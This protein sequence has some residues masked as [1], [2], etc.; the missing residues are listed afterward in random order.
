MSFLP[1]LYRSSTTATA[2]AAFK[3][4]NDDKWFESIDVFVYDNNAYMGDVGTQDI[5]IQANDIYYL[6]HPVNLNDFFFRNVG[7]GANTRVVVAGVL[8]SDRR[9]RELGIS[10]T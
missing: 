4:V 10:V 2:D 7:A 5:L 9:K 6:L 8:L 1:L 3:L